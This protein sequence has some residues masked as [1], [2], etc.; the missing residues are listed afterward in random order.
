MSEVSNGGAPKTQITVSGIQG[1]L[2][3]GLSRPQIAAKYALS[4]KDLKELFSHPKLKGLK[5]KPAP[6][7]ILTDDTSNAEEV[8]AETPVV[9]ETTDEVET[10]TTEDN[11]TVGDNF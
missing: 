11:V 6:S 7:F 1:D 2:N 5:T 10:L 4:N 3:N 9:E 8:V